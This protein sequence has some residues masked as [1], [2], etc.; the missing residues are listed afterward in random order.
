MGTNETVRESEKTNSSYSFNVPFWLAQSVF[1]QRTV[2]QRLQVSIP[3]CAYSD[4][5]L[6][7]LFPCNSIFDWLGPNE[8]TALFIATYCHL[9]GPVT[10]DVYHTMLGEAL[11]CSERAKLEETKWV[12]APN[13]LLCSL[14]N[15][16]LAWNMTRIPAMFFFSGW[17]SREKSAPRWKVM[18][19]FRGKKKRQ[20][21]Q[22]ERSRY[23]EGEEK[24]N[25]LRDFF[26]KRGKKREKRA[27]RCTL[28]FWLRINS[29][30]CFFRSGA[31]PV[32]V[33]STFFFSRLLL[34]PRAGEWRK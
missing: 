31:A 12:C 20:R 7:F 8:T 34:F 26:R 28:S 14:P 27:V 3:R 15:L 16:K 19:E 4:P 30:P 6:P 5:G 9:K 29:S 13:A 21:T 25:N 32:A 17:N 23:V 11:H 22:G 24:M 10:E 1:P 33:S 18:K 2:L